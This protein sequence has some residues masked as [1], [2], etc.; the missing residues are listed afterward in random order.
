MVWKLF[1]VLLLDETEEYRSLI[2]SSS[3]SK[4]S[5]EA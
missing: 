1:L 2:L 3:G 4:D 5:G